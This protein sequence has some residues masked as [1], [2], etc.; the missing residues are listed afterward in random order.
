MCVCVCVRPEES[1]KKKE[2][3]DVKN[4]EG[5]MMKRKN[6]KVR[7]VCEELRK[8]RCGHMFEAESMKKRN[9]RST[10]GMNESTAVF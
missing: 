2:R 7:K 8:R 6:R 4:T 9:H 1:L 5:E 10:E 3:C